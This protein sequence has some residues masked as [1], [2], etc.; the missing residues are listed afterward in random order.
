MIKVLAIGNSFSQ[1]ATR[2]LYQI[3]RADKVDMKV[4]NLCIGG[5]PLSY[6]YSNTLSEEKRYVF[7]LNGM[8]TGINVSLKEGLSNEAWNGWDFITFQQVSHMSNNYDTY[9]PYLSGLSEYVK[10]YS[11]KAKQMIHQTWAYEE[12]GVRL[13]QELGYNNQLEMFKDVEGAYAKA[14]RDIGADI[15]PSGETMQNLIKSGKIVHRDGFHAG[16]GYARYALAL[17]WYE[18]ITGNSTENNTFRDFDVSVTEEEVA[19]AKKAA[20]DAVLK[21]KG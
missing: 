8:S 16:L 21:Y 2:Y 7:E 14:A 15:I 20:H 4:V 10:K 5:C 17:T 19:I 3:A 9:Q 1:D 12:G 11:P 6:H 13:T 18:A